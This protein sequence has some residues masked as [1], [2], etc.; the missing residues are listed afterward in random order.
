MSYPQ[1]PP[2]FTNLEHFCI[3]FVYPA[4]LKIKI[5][6]QTLRFSQG[7]VSFQSRASRVRVPFPALSQTEKQ[8]VLVTMLCVVMLTRNR[9]AVFFTS[10]ANLH[11]ILA[12]PYINRCFLIFYVSNMYPCMY[13]EMCL[14]LVFRSTTQASFCLFSIINFAVAS[15]VIEDSDVYTTHIHSDVTSNAVVNC[16]DDFV[17]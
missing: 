12:T 17:I 4:F 7:M 15:T 13:P 5:S 9:S 16:S 3:S 1:S 10:K 6:P 11:Q 8:P 2:Q 14:P